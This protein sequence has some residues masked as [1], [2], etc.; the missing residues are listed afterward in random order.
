[1]TIDSQVHST[2][3][4]DALQKARKKGHEKRR[5]EWKVEKDKHT[6]MTAQFGPPPTK[7]FPIS[8]NQIYFLDNCGL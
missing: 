6:R 7:S 5:G 4:S 8:S 1:M 3:E 2:E